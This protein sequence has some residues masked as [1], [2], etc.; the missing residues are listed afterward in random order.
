MA[1]YTTNGV[2]V[3]F[4]FKNIQLQPDCYYIRPDDYHEVTV[5]EILKQ[6]IEQGTHTPD[7]KFLERGESIK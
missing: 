6:C 4:Y 7:I 1:N 2:N 5:L 3:K